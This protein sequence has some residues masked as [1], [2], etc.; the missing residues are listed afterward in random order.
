MLADVLEAS[1]EQSGWEV[2]VVSSDE[3]VLE[4]AARAGARP[5]VEEGRSLLRA[6]RQVEGEVQGRNSRL[7]VL[8]GDLPFATPEALA[9]ALQRT[10][11]VVAVPAHS[12]GGTNLLVR[13]PPA[14]IPARFGGASFAKHRWAARRARV[15]FEEVDEAGLAFDLDRPADLDAVLATDHTGRTRQVC[16]E[17]DLPRRLRIKAGHA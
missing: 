7:A 3:A 6:V 15:S 9:E 5:V 14:I 16:L 11:A 1:L 4:V 8:L 17:L 2:W 12:D 10:A 13:H